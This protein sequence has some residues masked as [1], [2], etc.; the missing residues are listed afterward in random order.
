MWKEAFAFSAVLLQSKFF[1]SHPG[2]FGRPSF[3]S[4]TDKIIFDYTSSTC[5]P[6]KKETVYM[7]S[8]FSKMPI[9]NIFV[10]LLVQKQY[11]LVLSNRN[12]WTI[13][14]LF[15]F[16]FEK[17]RNRK[18]ICILNVLNKFQATGTSWF[19]GSSVILVTGKQQDTRIYASLAGTCVLPLNLCHH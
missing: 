12:K 1:I 7:V 2:S 3:A 18:N 16:Y 11:I 13:V 14:G 15:S 4:C 10:F 9:F 5:F 6:Y 17:K 19:S 8:F